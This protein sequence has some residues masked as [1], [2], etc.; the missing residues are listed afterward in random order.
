MTMTCEMHVW[1]CVKLCLASWILSVP[2]RSAYLDFAKVIIRCCG[3]VCFHSYF[4]IWECLF[5][6][7]SSC[8]CVN[9]HWRVVLTL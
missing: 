5:I 7:T 2:Y 6:N 9:V 1:L 8:I 4:S 3:S